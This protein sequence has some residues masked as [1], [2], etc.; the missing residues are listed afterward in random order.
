VKC[1]EK[2]LIKL[3]H[4][5]FHYLHVD[6]PPCYR[7]WAWPLKPFMG[8]DT[9]EQGSHPPPSCPFL[10]PLVTGRD[11]GGGILIPH[12]SACTKFNFLTKK[13]SHCINGFGETFA[14]ALDI[15]KAFDR[16]WHK[17]LISKL[18]SF[19]IYSSLCSFISNFLSG[20]SIETVVDDHC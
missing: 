3:D 13:W 6:P 5:I 2:W 10:S 4:Q 20:C 8:K 18:P 9:G 7:G 11:Y 19:G 12:H 17:S 1:W 14:V 16:V 15:S